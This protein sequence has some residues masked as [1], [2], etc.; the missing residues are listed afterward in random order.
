MHI[1][2][3]THSEYPD[4]LSAIPQPPQHLYIKGSLEVF[5]QPL[6]S[7]IDSRN[8]TSY[9]DFVLRTFVPPLVKA[10]LTIVSGLAYGA[11]I[12]AHQLA[13]EHGGTCIAVL[14]SGL[15]AIYP[16]IHRGIVQEIQEKG[17][18]IMSE[19]PPT[20]SPL[21]YHFP[22]RNRIISG[23]STVTLVVE[24]GKIRYCKYL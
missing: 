4:I 1:L 9:G 19:Y 22:Q 15:E 14:G 21:P 11:D 8:L 12:R 2:S 13:L 20:T 17:R 18:C 23:L 6:L 10:G 24:A 7:I 16:T 5:K 3:P